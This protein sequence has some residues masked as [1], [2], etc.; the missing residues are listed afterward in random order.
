[1]ISHR[2]STIV[3]NIPTSLY[4]SLITVLSIILLLSPSVL[5]C[6]PSILFYSPFLSL[7]F[8]FVAAIV[9]CLVPIVFLFLGFVIVSVIVR[10]VTLWSLYSIFI[11]FLLDPSVDSILDLFV[12][13]NLKLH[14]SFSLWFLSNFWS[15]NYIVLFHHCFPILSSSNCLFGSS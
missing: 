11:V 4:Y 8:V 2:S 5:F 14:R 10:F 1:M 13:L 15:V 12:T 6:S 9:I 7:Y 3:H